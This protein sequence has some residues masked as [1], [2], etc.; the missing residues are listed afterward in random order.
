MLKHRQFN[1]FTVLLILMPFWC[2]AQNKA[3]KL[4][5]E[6]DLSSLDS[7]SIFQLLDSLM[8]MEPE[9]AKSQWAMRA[10]YNSNITATG[11]PFE[12]GLFG[13]SGGSTFYHKSGIFID[14]T[15][16]WSMEYDPSYF[17]T[18][19]SL[20]YMKTDLKAWSLVAEYSRYFYDLSDDYGEVSYK[21]NFTAT[22]LFE[23]KQ[24][25]VRFD[26]S[27]YSGSK[28]GHRFT[29]TLSLNFAKRN[30]R[31]LKKIS[32]YPTASVMFGI[33]ELPTQ[34]IPQFT[35]RLDALFRIRNGLPLF[36][37]VNETAFGVMNYALNA[38]FTVAL[39]SWSFTLSYA[40]NIPKNLPGE[41]GVF[42]NSGLFSF[43]S[44]YYFDARKK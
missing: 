23:H 40:Y 4:P 7:L 27:L 25:N 36:A 11:R 13:I 5:V 44:V 14:A 37:E 24:L 19:A 20:G 29:P 9:E 33:E 30:W 6:S 21:N 34:Y 26:Y 18:V 8:N 10:G 12:L 32:F 28:I 31:K 2:I 15:G 38:P 1:R 35:N 42:S 16:Y 43:T 41:T 3:P 39:K 17:L 22:A